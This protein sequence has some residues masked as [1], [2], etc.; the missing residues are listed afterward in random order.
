MLQW[1]PYNPNT[2]EPI[3]KIVP[4]KPV[5]CVCIWNKRYFITIVAISLDELP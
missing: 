5:S 3:A 1:A 4:L 2:F